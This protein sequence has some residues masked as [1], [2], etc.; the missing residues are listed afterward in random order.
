MLDLIEQILLGAK[1]SER[2]AVCLVAKTRGSTPQKQGAI[3][4]VFQNGQTSGTLGGGCVEAE[5]KT[6]A[7]KSIQSARGSPAHV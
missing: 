2:L 7:L 6:R 1:T 4:L 5:V 3:M